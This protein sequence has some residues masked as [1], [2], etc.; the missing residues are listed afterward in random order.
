MN[1][2][3]FGAAAGIGLGLALSGAAAHATVAT[4]TYTGTT[5]QTFDGLGLFGPDGFGNAAFTAIFTLDTS[6]GDASNGCAGTTCTNALAE[7]VTNPLTASLTINGVTLSFLGNF[8]SGATNF[9]DSAC[10][11]ACSEM[12]DG[13]ADNSDN[14]FINLAAFSNNDPIRFPLS[15][16]TPL[17]IALGDAGNGNDFGS[18]GF[19]VS[20]GANETFAQF[21]VASVTVS[22]AVAGVPEPA[23]WALMLLGFGGLGAVLRGS[24]RREGLAAL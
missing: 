7:G 11:V 14:T 2:K 22:D 9:Q 12:H 17:N 5:T 3:R 15:L 18:G 8:S 24:R 1:F 21:R 10:A 19:T 23:A 16:T 13:V 4:I 6:K 20:Q